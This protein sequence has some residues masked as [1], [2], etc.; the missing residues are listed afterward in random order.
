MD[1]AVRPR[2]ADAGGGSVLMRRSDKEITDRTEI[3]AVIRGCQVCRLGFCDGGEPYIVPLCFGYDGKALYFHS[4]P[5][6]RKIDILHA[7]NRVCFEFDTVES[8]VRTDKACNWGISYRSVVGIG[9]AEILDDLEAKRHGL[10]MIMCQYSPGGFSFPD[11]AVDR[12]CI[13]R[14]AIERMTGK[15]SG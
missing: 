2:A 6:G 3:D 1:I 9:R 7:S 10:S 13:I 15:K 5:V 4:A 8:I 14:V 11:A 12:V